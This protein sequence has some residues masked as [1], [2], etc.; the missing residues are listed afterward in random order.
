MPKEIHDKLERQA[1]KKK[2]T[3]KK[4]DAYVFGALFKIEK[5]KKDKPQARRKAVGK[6][7]TKS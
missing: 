6:R 4:K 7:N 2:L 1:K 5:A 3:G